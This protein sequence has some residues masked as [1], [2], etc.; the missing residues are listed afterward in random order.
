MSLARRSFP[1]EGNVALKTV[2]PHERNPC[3][4]R[5]YRYER[6]EIVAAEDG[7]AAHPPMD[8]VRGPRRA[9]LLHVRGDL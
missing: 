9:Q 4:T 3:H 6:G 1:R 7:E 2:E 8:L 5:F